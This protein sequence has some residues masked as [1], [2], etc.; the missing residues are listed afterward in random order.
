MDSRKFYLSSGSIKVQY[1]DLIVCSCVTILF[2]TETIDK[3]I[4]IFACLDPIFQ[5]TSL[6]HGTIFFQTGG[7]IVYPSVMM[8]V[9]AA[10]ERLNERED[11]HLSDRVAVNSLAVTKLLMS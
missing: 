7:L 4:K 9:V 2:L 5:P 3:I 10:T 8:V 11:P 6:L 1:V